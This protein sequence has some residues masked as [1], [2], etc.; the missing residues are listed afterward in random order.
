MAPVRWRTA[1]VTG[2][3]SGI[4][5]AFAT[6]LLERGTSVV[7]V[8]RRRER[9][10]ELG[11]GVEV[12]VAD[13]AEDD[14]LAQVEAR[15]TDPERPVDLLVNAA[16]YGSQ[17]HLAELDA[18]YEEGQVRVNVLALSRL[19]QAALPGMV[20]R[21]HGGVVNVS[22]VAGHQPI[23]LWAT[24]AATKAYVTSYTRALAAELKGTGVRALLVLPGFTRTEFHEGTGFDRRLIP[25]PAWMDPE[26]VAVHALKAMD[27]GRTEA[28]PG[29]HNRVVAYASRMSPWPLTRTVLRVG[30]RHMW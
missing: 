8:A 28:I 29:I 4:G 1:L 6:T 15:L 18:D 22:S 21:R 17:G 27:K 26:A 7:A 9:L 5:R 2:A 30:M 14:G 23:P 16:G 10:A 24:Y 12:L 11:D 20:E 13:L 19:T 25:S 3:S